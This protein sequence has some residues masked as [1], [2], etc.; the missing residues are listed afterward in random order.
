MQE[1]TLATALIF[2]LLA[3]ILRPKYILIPYITALLWY[4]SY[5]AVRVGT[6]DITVGRIVVGVLLLR[7]LF[8]SRIKNK[9]KWFQLDTYVTLSMVVYVVV[10]CVSVPL[11]VAVENRAGF[12]MDVWFSYLVGR[13]CI[14]N[15]R[16]LVG[17][18][19]WVAI[20]LVP[21]AILGILESVTGW[22]A[23]ALLSGNSPAFEYLTGY[24]TR[25]GFF[26]AMGPFSHPILFGCG[27]AMFLP[28]IYCLR[29]EKGYWCFWGYVIS[30]VV[31]FGALSSMSGGPWIIV[32]A[33]I[34][35][36]AMEKLRHWH[37]PILIFVVVSCIL[38]EVVS[39]RHF[40]YV[41]AS[42]ANFLGGASWH[43]AKLIDVAI[44]HFSEWWLLGYGIKDPNWG[45]Y[46][47][48]ARTDVPNE[49]IMAGIRYGILGIIALCSVLIV[50][51]YHLSGLY[52]RTVDTKLKCLYWSLG[53]LLFSVTVAWMSTSF[54]GQLVSIFYCILG[55]I[56]SSLGFVQYDKVGGDRFILNR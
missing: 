46:F 54:F 37:K 55:I 2:S 18:I 49:F 48:M 3:I 53:T 12:L 34:F 51:F 29:H 9:F 52:K 44:E 5:L 56:G 23:F 1:F 22:R 43:R 31:A 8:D 35:C 15:Y 45:S 32:I 30:I 28:L 17:F 41:F 16:Q 39:N 47:G 38:T 24:G 4:P 20:L 13:F 21:L 36:I 7:C 14:T 11:S 50:A 33:V 6:V 27:F 42:H 25:W 26:R 40:Y 10:F 19:K